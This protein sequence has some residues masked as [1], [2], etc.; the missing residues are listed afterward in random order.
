[1]AIEYDS[2]IEL[3]SDFQKLLRRLLLN[4]AIFINFYEILYGGYLKICSS[5]AKVKT[6][7]RKDTRWGWTEE[8]TRNNLKANPSTSVIWT[9]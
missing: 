4:F 5:K 2:K 3:F 8:L 1:M 6:K 9:I 7:Q